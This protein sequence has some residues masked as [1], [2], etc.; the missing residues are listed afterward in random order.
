MLRLSARSRPRERS[1]WRDLS[2]LN[3]R[4]HDIGIVAG[5]SKDTPPVGQI[6]G[7]HSLR[8]LHKITQNAGRRHVIGESDG[9]KLRAFLL[10]HAELYAPAEQEAP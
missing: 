1:T 4:P 10:R 9:H 5:G 3:A 2:A 8:R 7:H 6:N